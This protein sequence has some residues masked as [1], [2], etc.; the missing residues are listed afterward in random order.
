MSRA[1]QIAAALAVTLRNPNIRRAEAAWGAAI[2]AEWLHFVALGVFAY[3]RGGTA[4]VG[5]A[6]LVRLL[7]AAIVAPF[8][9]SLGDRFRR[10]R[11]LLATALV[12]AAALAGS[13]A[14]AYADDR[15]AVFVLAAVVGI[16]STLV[17]PALQALL[18]SV[19]RTPAELIASNGA[20]S[21]VENVGTLAGPLLAGVL[22]AAANVGVVF[23][24]S[25]A[26]LAAAAVLFVRVRVSD[27]FAVG[28]TSAREP[29]RRTAGAGLDAILRKPGA[30]VLVA[31]GGA[32]S[33]VRGCLNVLIVVVVFRVLHTRSA[34]VGYLTA[35]IGLGGLAGAFGATTLPSRRLATLFGAALVLWGAPIALLAPL[36]FL[37]T[38]LVLLAF[39]GIA[40]SVE[41]VAIITLLQRTIP[42]EMLTRGMAVLWALVMGGVALGSIAAPPLISL[43]GP[44]PTF[45]VVGAILPLLVLATRRRLA[46]IDSSALPARALRLID[47]VPM[48]GPLSLAAK[49]RV[50]ASVVP[51]SVTAGERVIRAGDAAD[52]FYIVDDGEFSVDAGGRSAR[53]R[54]GDYFGEIAMLLDVPRTADVTAVTDAHV[55]RLDRGAFLAAV[56]GNAAARAA[57]RAVVEARLATG[58]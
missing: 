46:A 34:D 36:P 1:A 20:T 16:S 47:G 29:W 4:A 9:A 44:R 31:L 22:V 41:D 51:V 13:S 23:A 12:G 38:A 58:P 39:V 48:F 18:P 28:A 53:L 33:F 15:V 32:Q 19:S 8:A 2:S 11:F 50:A 57:G 25:A 43:M 49:E 26:M 40:N 54:E 30:R 14:A 6:G 37:A 5:V 42:E 56:T 21:I 52:A 7:P 55:Y 45:V 27:A 3:E 10:E 24:T 17:R 35:A